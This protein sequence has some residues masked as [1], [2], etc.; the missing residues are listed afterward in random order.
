MKMPHR[1]QLLREAIGAARIEMR[2][3][4]VAPESI[5]TVKRLC[6]KEYLGAVWD[7]WCESLID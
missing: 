7:E 5:R 6:A 1:I 2:Y 3:L 4:E